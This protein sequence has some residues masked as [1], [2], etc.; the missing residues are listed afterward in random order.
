MLPQQ[1]KPN[2][3]F[4]ATSYINLDLRMDENIKIIS[5]LPTVLLNGSIYDHDFKGFFHVSSNI[6]EFVVTKS[7][8]K[9]LQR[10]IRESS[11]AATKTLIFYRNHRFYE[12]FNEKIQQLVSAGIIDHLGGYDKDLVNPKRFAK[13]NLDQVQPMNLQHLEAGFVIWMISLMIPVTVFIFEW[14]IRF[15]DFIV[16]RFIFVAYIK[17]LER[18]LQNRHLEV[19]KKIE[20]INN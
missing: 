13:L 17:T 1:T 3:P 10:I 9:L 15:K 4:Q 19:Q 20:S 8:G 16:F 14:I 6:L 11:L 5:N 7:K 2:V 12:S 18:D